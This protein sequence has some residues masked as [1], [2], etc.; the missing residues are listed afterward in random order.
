MPTLNEFAR[1]LSACKD[2]S[3]FAYCV[4]EVY[5]CGYSQPNR[6]QISVETLEK[7][8][9]RA[10]CS[11]MVSWVLYMGG[12]LPECPWFYTAVER[13]YLQEHDFT[14]LE[15]GVFA[16]QRN[17][18]LWRS[19]HTAI[20]I[21]D[22]LVA[23]L[24]HDENYDAG[25]EGEEAGDQTGDESRL[26]SYLPYQWDY[27]LR[28]NG[29]DEESED[30][31]E[32]EDVMSMTFIFR[33]NDDEKQPLMFYDGGFIS[34][35]ENDD[36]RVAAQEAY[37]KVTGKDLPLI[38]IGTK[39]AP[40]GTRFMS[41]VQRKWDLL[42]RFAEIGAKIDSLRALVLKIVNKLGAW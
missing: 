9:A 21:G 27:I 18:V 22:G 33:P 11:S 25:W 40:Y 17:D 6:R 2:P 10:D 7:G 38:S 32:S 4:C 8:I 36:E 35:I 5:S 42:D 20:Y 1:T 13:D 19:G 14:E 15:C 31:E 26:I 34:V 37:K 41:M 23:E 39:E 30:E 3:D 29:R 16:P 24:I 28:Y 12:F